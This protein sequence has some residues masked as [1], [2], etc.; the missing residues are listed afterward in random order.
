V[1]EPKSADRLIE[2]CIKTF[3]RLDILVNNV[4]AIGGGAR[5]LESTDEDWHAAM[6]INFIQALRIIR[7]AVP[8]MRA[9]GGGAIVNIT[10]IS[11]WIPQLVR[12]GQYGAS[13]AALI[14]NTERLALEFV[15]YNIRVNAVSPGSI[16]CDGNGWDRYRERD[17]AGFKEYERVGFPMGR[18]GKPEEIADVVIFLS[19]GR[20]HWI[21]GRHIAVDGLEQPFDRPGRTPF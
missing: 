7:A 21:N 15:P 10:S 17:P 9:N 16:I 6:E 20:A 19:S 11:G 4:G 12:N 14:Y 1:C 13:K 5:L 8:P 2:R 18:L 3:G